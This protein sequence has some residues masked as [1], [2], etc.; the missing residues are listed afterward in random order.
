MGVSANNVIGITKFQ[1]CLIMQFLSV[2]QQQ[3]RKQVHKIP[4]YYQFY[5]ISA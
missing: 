4:I 2:E 1:L 5:R 3:H